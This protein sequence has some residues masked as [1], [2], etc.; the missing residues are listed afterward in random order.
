MIPKILALDLNPKSPMGTLTWLR[1]QT[2]SLRWKT[3]NLHTPMSKNRK[4]GTKVSVEQSCLKNLW[5]NPTRTLT[6]ILWISKSIHSKKCTNLL[7]PWKQSR[8]SNWKARKVSITR[9]YNNTSRK[10]SVQRTSIAFKHKIENP[11][12]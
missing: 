7:V 6:C 4:E 3:K 8:F 10:S 11:R 2:K 1:V 9:M 5:A 12:N